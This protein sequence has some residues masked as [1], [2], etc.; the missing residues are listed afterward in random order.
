MNSEMVNGIIKYNLFVSF[1][2]LTLSNIDT[3]RSTYELMLVYS[4]NSAIVFALLIFQEVKY[5]SG[6]S[7]NLP[8]LIGYCFRL[9][10]PALQHSFEAIEGEQIYFLVDANVVNDYMFPTCIW[11]NIYYMIFYWCIVRYTK[12]LS[13]EDSI[14]PFF[15]RFK[16][17]RFSIVLFILGL[18]YNILISFVPVGVVPGFIN[19]IFGKLALLAIVAQ[20]FDALFNPTPFR[21]KLFLLFIISSIIQSTFYG[22]YKGPIVMNMIYYVLYYFLDCKYNNKR[23]VSLKF[24]FT[25]LFI[26][27]SIDLIIYPFMTTKRI[28]SGWDVTSGAIATNQYSNWDILVDV[29]NGKS[30]SERGENTA[31]SRF[32]AI[33]ANAFFYK[34]C[35]TRGLRTAEIM[36]NNLELLVPRF[37][38]P[39][40]HNSEAGLMVYAYATTGSFANKDT[41]IS[42]NYIGQFAS[43][44]LIGGWICALLLAFVNGWF[45]IFYYNFLVRHD[46]NIF[47]IL[48]L[49]PLLLNAIYAFEEVHDGGA[50]SIGYNIVMMFVIYFS[51]RFLPFLN[52]KK[53]DNIFSPQ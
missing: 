33:P 26:V 39:N 4:I 37:I 14:R 34:E 9:V 12:N 32:D 44:Y 8:L 53:N 27:L 6:L 2:L 45:T 29:I 24:I 11:M 15:Q 10:I 13:I 35:Q 40:K 30:L 49:I 19:S 23:I 41:A 38:N 28:V 16:V 48:F 42:N 31:S 5:F 43:A 21:K 18:C 51:S 46:Y 36:I 25:C 3:V 20:M 47:S 50:L 22:F 17:Y 52:F 1:I 7:L